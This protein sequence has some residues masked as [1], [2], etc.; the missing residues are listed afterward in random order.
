MVRA[1]GICLDGPGFNPQSGRLFCLTDRTGLGRSIVRRIS[2]EVLGDKE[3]SPR[4]CPSKLSSHEQHSIIRQ[5]RSRRLDNAVQV[6]QF[7]NFTITTPVTL[8]TVRNVLKKS[9]FHSATKKNVPMLKKTHKQ[10]R[11]EF[12]HYHENWTVEDFKEVLWLDE[13]KIN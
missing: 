8:Q 2:K 13:T 5:I 10:K 3:N 1:S 9:G 11:L 12:A 6:T 4:G 7:I